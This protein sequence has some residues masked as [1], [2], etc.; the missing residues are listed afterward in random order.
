MYAECFKLLKRT[1]PNVFLLGKHVITVRYCVDKGFNNLFLGGCL[2]QIAIIMLL[3]L[4]E[5]CQL[6]FY[7]NGR[8][9][10]LCIRLN[11][12]FVEL[13]EIFYNFKIFYLGITSLLIMA[14]IF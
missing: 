1:T 6:F 11:L 14:H 2:S 8:P 5:N 4:F 9:I 12:N 10:G 3:L 7:I 13:S